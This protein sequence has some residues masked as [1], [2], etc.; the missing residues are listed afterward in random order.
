MKQLRKQRRAGA[1]NEKDYAEYM[2]LVEESVP[3]TSH[4]SYVRTVKSLFPLLQ[5][6][7]T[8]LERDTVYRAVELLSRL[9]QSTENTTMF[10]LCPNEFLETLVQ[11]LVVSYTAVE[12][13]ELCAPKAVRHN[14][15]APS[16]GYYSAGQ[17]ASTDVVGLY[18][19]PELEDARIP[20]CIGE[21]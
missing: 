20:L 15:H 10:S 16:P 11:L 13:L 6:Y 4:V 17:C 3:S 7:L 18:E 19:E 21:D 1:I 2:S 5:R 14:F 9:A 12:P 8:S